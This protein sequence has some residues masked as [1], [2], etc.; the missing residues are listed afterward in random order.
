[1]GFYGGKAE[2]KAMKKDAY[3]INTA[4][5]SKNHLGIFWMS[6]EDVSLICLRTAITESNHLRLHLESCINEVV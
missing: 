5:F 1:M 2:F 4:Q 6:K 3:L